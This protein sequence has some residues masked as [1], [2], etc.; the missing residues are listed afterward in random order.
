MD[1]YLFV[2]RSKNGKKVKGRI[3]INNIEELNQIMIHHNYQLLSYKKQKNKQ[4]ISLFNRITKN[5]LLIFS[6]NLYLMMKAGIDLKKALSLCSEA[7]NKTKFKI[8]ILDIEKEIEK[9]KPISLVLRS[10]QD[11]FPTYFCTMFSLSEKSGNLLNILKHLVDTYRFEINLMKK[12]RNAMFYP[13][14][15]LLLSIVII[16]VISTVVIPTFVVV[17]EQM[18]V[19]LP[20]ITKIMI[21]LSSFI[22]NN[23][24]YLLLGM[25][26]IIVSFICFIKTKKGKYIF[27]KIKIKLPIFKKIYILNLSSKI[28]RSLSILINSGLP[29]VSS[30]QTTAFLLNNDYVK[31]RFNF[32]IDEVKRGLEISQALYYLDF[33]PHVMIETTKVSEQTSSLAISFNNLANLFDE[34]EHAKLQKLVTIIEPVFILIIALIVVV[35]VI[36]IFIPLF[37]MLDN[38]GEF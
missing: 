29:T 35:L 34:D 18:N 23:L 22:S 37:S 11:V 30:L 2:A 10:Y 13:C 7:T 28:C 24:I 27:D 38:I 26:I 25:I 1:K 4:K 33:L 36:A 5:D 17:F 3:E 14:L 8:I 19:E 20:L 32:V 15:L 9:G 6:E 16:I 12:I 21:F 31:E